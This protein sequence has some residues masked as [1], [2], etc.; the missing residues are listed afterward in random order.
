MATKTEKNVY[1]KLSRLGCIL[2]KQIDIRNLDDS[3]VEMHH[4]RRFGGKR[5]LA[6]VIPLCAIHH[7]LG[8]SAIHNL[9]HKG[10]EKYWGFSEEDLLER[11]NEQI[12]TEN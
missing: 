5:E 12:R 11:L 3:P 6:P 7:R 10:F 8:D 2:C 9:G 1:L 4:V